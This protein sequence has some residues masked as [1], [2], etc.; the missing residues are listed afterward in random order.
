MKNINYRSIMLGLTLLG[1]TTLIGFNTPA[2]ARPGDKRDVKR[3]KREVK[4][5]KRELRDE[6][7]EARRPGYRRPGYR[8][9]TAARPVY[10]RPSTRPVYSRPYNQPRTYTGYVTQDTS[11]ND[12][13][14]NVNGSPFRVYVPNGEPSAISRGDRVRVRG[15]LSNGTISTN[16]VT[17]LN[18]R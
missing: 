7:K 15:I 13:L 10:R 4:E 18:N 2:S 8:R 6:R 17:I 12:F 1:T 3:A 14:L 11:G 5:A 9:P 16:A